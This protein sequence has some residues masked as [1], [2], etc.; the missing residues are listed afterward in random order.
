MNTDKILRIQHLA[1][2]LGLSRA[3]I[4]RMIKA[5]KLPKGFKIYGTAVGWRD[6]D[7][8]TWIEETRQ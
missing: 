7:I 6:S 8:N 1:N 2:K 4:Y 5:N 3:T